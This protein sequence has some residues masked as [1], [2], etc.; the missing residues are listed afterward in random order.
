MLLWCANDDDHLAPS[1]F[2]RSLCDTH[3]RPIIFAKQTPD[4]HASATVR[5]GKRRR[6]KTK[7]LICTNR[8]T[9][10]MISHFSFIYILA[11][12]IFVAF[13]QP[14]SSFPQF[15]LILGT[16]RAVPALGKNKQTSHAWLN[17]CAHNL[18]TRTRNAR[19][20]NSVKGIS[21]SFVGFVGDDGDEDE[22]DNEVGWKNQ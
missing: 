11:R 18:H 2:V 17:R 7:S 19:A 20:E 9:S 16:T 10:A 5:E 6:G 21:V 15:L 8:I 22:D 1:S 3:H 4:I 14:P 12:T 13:I